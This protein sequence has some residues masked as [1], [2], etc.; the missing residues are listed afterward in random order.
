MSKKISTAYPPYLFLMTL[1]AIGLV[2]GVV[3]I[4]LTVSPIP[5]YLDLVLIAMVLISIGCVAEIMM[6]IL[7]FLK[8]QN[9][10]VIFSKTLLTARVEF[11]AEEVTEIR[12]ETPAGQPT[13]Q[14]GFGKQVRLC[15]IL[16]NG[17]RRE[18]IPFSALSPRKRERVLNLLKEAGI[19]SIE[20]TGS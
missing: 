20:G 11:P 1:I 19:P 7:T 8:V 13:E 14:F 18:R 16:K 17:A 2:A 6:S 4:S 9:G 10:Q 3:A 5:W 15:F 12:F